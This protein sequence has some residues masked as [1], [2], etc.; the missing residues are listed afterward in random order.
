MLISKIND[1]NQA[2]QIWLQKKL[3]IDEMVLP[4]YERPTKVIK[5][6]GQ[7]PFQSEVARYGFLTAIVKNITP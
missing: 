7:T 2:A 4:D 5:E 6:I 3:E 1:S